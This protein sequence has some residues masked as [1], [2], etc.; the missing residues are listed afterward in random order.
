MLFDDVYW[1]CGVICDCYLGEFVCL[2][3]GFFF[4]EGISYIQMVMG[5]DEVVVFDFLFE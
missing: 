2:M 1:V 3:L 5:E 4:Y